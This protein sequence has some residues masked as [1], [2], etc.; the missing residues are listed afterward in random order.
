MV[1]AQKLQE[2][3]SVDPKTT[4]LL[5]ICIH[6]YHCPKIIGEA[7]KDKS[8]NL[9]EAQ[10]LAEEFPNTFSKPSTEVIEPLEKGH[11]AKLIF[12]FVSDDPEV[13]SSEQ[14][15][16]EILLVQNNKFLG[17]LEDGPKYIQDLKCGEIIEFE[18]CHIIDID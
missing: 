5:Y 17:Q 8:W 4:L 12:K 3:I 1:G 16:V 15:W 2:Q 18:E 6:L 14:L 7:V 11:K 13:P 9:E 10:K